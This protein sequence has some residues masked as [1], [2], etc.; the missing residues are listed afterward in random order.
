V[1]LDEVS[2]VSI[3]SRST[4]LSHL[5]LGD[6]EEAGRLDYQ[7]SKSLEKQQGECYMMLTK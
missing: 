5:L 6:L 1:Q 4:P 3:V 7:S 2:S